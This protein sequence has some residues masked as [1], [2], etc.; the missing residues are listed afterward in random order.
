MK[1]VVP[2]CRAAAARGLEGKTART[3]VPDG[4]GAQES[5]G[6]GSTTQSSDSAFLR[7]KNCIWW[8]AEKQ[9]AHTGPLL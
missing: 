2:G 4:K 7:T 6:L 8:V 5:S 3:V 9:V 1:V